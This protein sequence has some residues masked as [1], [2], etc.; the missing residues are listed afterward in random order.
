[1]GPAGEA[2]EATTREAAKDPAREDV[3]NDQ[4][5]SSSTPAPSRYLLIGAALFVGI[6]GAA[7]TITPIEGEVFDEEI[8]AAA[9]L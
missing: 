5:S 2:I 9:R 7:G 8:L 6:P 1:M 4:P 3:V